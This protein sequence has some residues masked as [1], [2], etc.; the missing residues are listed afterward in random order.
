MVICLFFL[1][2]AIGFLRIR[3]IFGLLNIRKTLDND[4]CDIQQN[5]FFNT[6]SSLPTVLVH[7][8]PTVAYWLLI[9]VMLLGVVG[10][11]IP[12]I[13]G[14]SLIVGAVVA[15]GFIYGWPQVTIPLIVSIIVF[16]LCFAIEYLAGVLGG[17]KAGAS[18]WGQVG[19]MIGLG[20]GFFGMLPALPVGGPLLG[21]FFGPFIGAVVGEILYLMRDK[22]L[23]ALDRLQKS[24]KA[25][26][27]I[28][29]GSLVGLVMQGLLSLGALMV[30]L[31]N[32]YSHG[33]PA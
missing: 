15:A 25:G 33:W 30:F 6:M 10:A 11:F 29:A 26:I 20:L 8:L 3:K 32:T 28:V 17:Q 22:S 16:A 23:S 12:A 1:L 31:F 7:W 2:V 24:L 14:P 4:V 18:H 21:I 19:A 27:G 5:H 13:P 9:A